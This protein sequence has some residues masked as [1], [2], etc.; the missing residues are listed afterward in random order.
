VNSDRLADVTFVVEGIYV[1]IIYSWV[2]LVVLLH[3]NFKVAVRAANKTK[4][5]QNPTKG[6]KK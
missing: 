1:F 2:H 5:R 3:M 4:E 6:K